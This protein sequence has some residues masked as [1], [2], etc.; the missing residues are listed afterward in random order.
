MI[1]V[2]CS[3]AILHIMH[4]ALRRLYL[5]LLL[6]F[7]A[8]FR[9]RSVVA[10]ADEL[11]ISPSAC[12]HA[13]ARLRD[14]LGDALFFRAGSSMQP[15]PRA[16]EMAEAIAQ[17]LDVLS[18][19]LGES[20]TFAAG[21]SAQSFTFAATDFTTFALIPALV[22]RI[23]HEAPHV[24]LRV[25]HSRHREACN[26]LVQEGAH[27]VMGFSDE[28]SPVQEGVEVLQ[29]HADAYVVVARQGHP[30]I[31]KK[32]SMA[33]YLEE[34]HVVVKP[35]QEET[36]VIDAAL[37]KRGWAR[38]IAVEVPSVMAAPFIVANS[39]LLITLPRLAARQLEASAAI[40]IFEA[41]FELPSYTLNVYFQHR[42]LHHSW[43]RWMRSQIEAV[44][45]GTSIGP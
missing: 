7:D 31:R 26:D 2:H 6:V 39:D 15:T 24:H 27:F 11:A 33:Q 18:G 14:G 16:T 13:L 19:Q 37:N 23:E 9:H 22:S 1:M 4:S 21:S 35:W 36:G 17:A 8:L 43:H 20:A 12:S 44:L 38:Q 34:R 41:P 28:F 40:T 25:V 3:H 5:N 10:A 29:G 45:Q 30:R 42:H 32:L